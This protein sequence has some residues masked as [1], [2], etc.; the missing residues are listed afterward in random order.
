MKV[1]LRKK[2]I[3][4]K[5]EPSL[6]CIAI[7]AATRTRCDRSSKVGCFFCSLHTK[8][9]PACGISIRGSRVFRKVVFVKEYLNI[10]YFIDEFKIVY[11]H[12]DVLKNKRNPR[13]IGKWT[14]NY[15]ESYSDFKV[16]LTE[17]D[18]PDLRSM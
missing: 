15:L 5:N 8:R 17:P 16:V 12:G 18:V 3:S 7:N 13:K 6:I 14:G 1:A 4:N 11:D 2:I 10:P 9:F